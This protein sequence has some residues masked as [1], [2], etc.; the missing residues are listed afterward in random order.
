MGNERRGHV[1]P[2][3]SPRT[4]LCSPR[5]SRGCC[6][7]TYNWTYARLYNMRDYASSTFRK[8]LAEPGAVALILGGICMVS[9]QVFWCQEGTE[10]PVP[11][12]FTG[13]SAGWNIK[14]R[15]AQQ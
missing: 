3:P 6:S 5:N 9:V 13:S 2:P 12:A 15:S 7:G 11:F 4:R 10:N 8:Y 1:A 14:P